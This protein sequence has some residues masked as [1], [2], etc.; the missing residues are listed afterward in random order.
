VNTGRRH[1]RHRYVPPVRRLCDPDDVSII[2]T[3]RK[4]APSASGQRDVDSD[5]TRSVPERHPGVQGVRAVSGAP[6]ARRSAPVS[7]A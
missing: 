3:G 2:A 5:P 1:L 6:T 4:V 7:T